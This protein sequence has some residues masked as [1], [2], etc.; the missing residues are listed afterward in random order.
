M[1]RLL[2]AGG[3]FTGIVVGGLVAGLFLWHTTGA[4]WWVAVGLLGGLLLGIVVVAAAVRPFLR[5]N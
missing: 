4:S 1:T 5:T 2:A 3:A